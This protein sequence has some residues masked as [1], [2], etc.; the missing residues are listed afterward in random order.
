MRTSGKRPTS[1]TTIVSGA[2]SLLLGDPLARR[3]ILT[4]VYM[5]GTPS[6]LVNSSSRQH[7][8]PWSGNSI[9]SIC[10]SS[11]VHM[12][13]TTLLHGDPLTRQPSCTLIY[14]HGNTFARQPICTAAHLPSSRGVFA[15]ALAPPI[16]RR[17]LLTVNRG[18]RSVAETTTTSSAATRPLPVLPPP[19][20]ARCPGGSSL[21]DFHRESARWGSQEFLR[22][23]ETG[24]SAIYRDA[25]YQ[26]VEIPFETSSCEGPGR[27]TLPVGHGPG[28]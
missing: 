28:P 14:K 19:L 7:T 11:H 6:A 1:T 15:P 17:G 22:F 20:L 13:V 4:V 26:C 3:P 18:E 10:T 16:I 9:E 5:H 23:A 27:P 21:G 25:L 8:C 24:F 2:V 12:V